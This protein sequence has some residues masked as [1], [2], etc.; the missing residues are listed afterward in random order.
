MIFSSPVFVLG[1]LPASLLVYYAALKGAGV[2]A[3]NWALLL[4]SMLFY[5]FGG[6]RAFLILLLIIG[7]N[8]FLVLQ[9]ERAGRARPGLRKAL[10]LAVL[11]IDLGNLLY[12][13]Y[14]GFL[15]EN[16]RAAAAAAGISLFP[17]IFRETLPIGI[18][19]YT[20]QILS[21]A[22]DVYL[23]RTE[24]QRN[25]FRL[26]LYVIMY[27]QL[28]AGPIVR[29]TDVER[30]IS[31]RQVTGEELEEGIRRFILGFSKKVLIADTLGTAVDVI[32]GMIPDYGRIHPCHA[33]LGAVSYTFQIYFDFSGYSDMAIGLGKML[34][35]RFPENFESPYRAESIRDF[36]RRWHISLASWFRDYVYIPLGGSRRGGLLTVRNLLVVF[37][38]TGLWHGAAWNFV[39]WGLFN[40]FLLVAE[41]LF[42]GKWLQKLPYV[43]R[44]VYTSLAVVTGFVLF[45]SESMGIALQYLQNMYMPWFHNG[46]NLAV[47]QHTGNSFRVA[48]AAAFVTACLPVKLP[49]IRSAAAKAGYLLLWGLALCCLTG[50]AFNP[51]IYFRF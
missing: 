25:P 19:F 32:F 20:F 27:P 23:R 29:Y 7:L 6:I 13:K 21:Y 10:F 1:F 34:G 44:R 46:L 8:W 22:A 2:R 43:F 37:F 4:F 35:F 24:V 26:A 31:A 18:S 33:W 47:M 9:M 30:E 45:R 49:G 50:V 38:L 17:E 41:R 14:A 16:L 11:A 5:A 39:F 3:A 28:I 48:L 42:L 40:G 51:F 15:Q 12:F 36:W